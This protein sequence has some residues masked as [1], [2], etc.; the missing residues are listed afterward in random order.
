MK[1]LV[2]YSLF[3]ILLLACN[4]SKPDVSEI[5]VNVNIN[6]FDKDLFST[7]VN[8]LDSN[9]KD[10]SVKY[11]RYWLMYNKGVLRTGNPSDK[12]FTDYIKK[13][14]FDKNI[15]EVYDTCSVVF[16]N[17]EKEEKEL[18]MAFR[19]AKYYFP[20]SEIPKI[21]FHISGFNQ[22]IAVDSAIISVSIDNYLGENSKFYDML[23]IPIPKY[24]RTSMKKE[25]IPLDILKAKALTSFLSNFKKDNLIS[26][27]LYNGKILYFLSKVFPDR[28]ESFIMDYSHVQY[29]W[30]TK[31]EAAA[32][33][34]FIENEYV[35]S[36]DHFII[37]KYTNNSPF[38]SGMPDSSPGRV[39]NWIGLQIIKSYMINNEC[40]LPDLMIKY[41]YDA[42]LRESNY[43]PQ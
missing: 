10:L 13:F 14:I 15:R 7:D 9:L 20:T 11:G 21:Y 6:R 29:E 42:I 17:I 25:R 23:S 26:K 39:A 4:N 28:E 34:F 31:N 19:Y 36:S 43:Q 40:S 32:W 16:E 35:Y 22:S 5:A 18:E 24:Q 2:L 30:C 33:A 8:N 12:D 37:N 3:A 38:T 27:M 41:D 1:K